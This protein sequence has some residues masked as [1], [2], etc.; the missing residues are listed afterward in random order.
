MID[1]LAIPRLI[2]LELYHDQITV[3]CLIRRSR[4]L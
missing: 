3:R 1:I 2:Q 4:A